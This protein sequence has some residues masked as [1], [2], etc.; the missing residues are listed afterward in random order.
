MKYHDP[1]VVLL[2]AE[3]VPVGMQDFCHLL[4]FGKLAVHQTMTS[5]T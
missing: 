4:A 2:P 3:F 5:P 1:I